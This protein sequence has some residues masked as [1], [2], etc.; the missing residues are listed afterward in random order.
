MLSIQDMWV[1]KGDR[2]LSRTTL[3]TPREP[4]IPPMI[5]VRVAKEVTRQWPGTSA[6]GFGYSLYAKT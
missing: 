4:G 6:W 1:K 5:V 2:T 3:T